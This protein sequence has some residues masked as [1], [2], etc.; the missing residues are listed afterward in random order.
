MM[1]KWKC[2]HT[3]PGICSDCGERKL[4]EAEHPFAEKADVGEQYI[5]ELERG[6]EGAHVRDCG[7]SPER[8]ERDKFDDSRCLALRKGVPD[9]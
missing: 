8:F 4:A 6:L 5:K 1:K 9:A 7:C 3:N 2:G